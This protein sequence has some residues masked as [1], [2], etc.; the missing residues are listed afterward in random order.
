L[1][2]SRPWRWS[3]NSIGH[4]RRADARRLRAI[5]DSRDELDVNWLEIAIRDSDGK[6]TCCNNFITD[7]SVDAD[8]VE[9]LAAA[10]RTRW[11]I[12]NETFNTLK[13]RGYNFGHGKNNLSAVL[14]TLSLVAFASRPAAELADLAWKAA[15]DVAGARVRFCND[16]RALTAYLL[17]PSWDSLLKTLAFQVPPPLPS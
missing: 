10:G 12:E 17:F 9:D 15:I 4:G 1:R 13:N 6:T 3:A 8:N 11:K 2:T 5:C 14:V 16:L 7:L